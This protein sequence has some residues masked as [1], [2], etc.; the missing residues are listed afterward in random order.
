LTLHPGLPEHAA[1]IIAEML[2]RSLE[3]TP[4]ISCERPIRST[5]VCFIPLFGGAA[6][7]QELV[8][9]AQRSREQAE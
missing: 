2:R 9:V 5:L 1:R 4:G 8:N 6:P 7:L 3:I